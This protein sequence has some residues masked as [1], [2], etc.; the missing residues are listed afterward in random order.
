[1]GSVRRPPPGP[2]VVLCAILLGGCASLPTDDA[3]IETHAVVDT[4]GTHLGQAVVPLVDQHPGLTGV[5]L[6]ARGAD[7]F[8][9]RVVLAE[10]A[11]RTLDLQYFSWQRDVVGRLLADSVLRAADRGV[12]VRLLLDDVG[13]AARD[14]DLLLLDAHPGIEVRLF[15][16]LAN[17]E[18][19]TLSFI[20]DFA[21]ANRRM[22]NKSFTADN[23]VAILGGRNIG[24]EYFEAHAEHDFR[25]RGL[26]AIGPVVRQVSA[27]FDLYWNSDATFR[28]R[29]LSRERPSAED[30]ARA[31]ADLHAFVEVQRESVYAAAV[32]GSA[33]VAEL[34]S[35][36]LSLS[37]GQATVV[38]DDPA[39]INAE[40][41]DRA[42]HLAPKLR[43]ALDAVRE[44][45]IFVS[46]YFVPGENGVAVLRG[47]RERGIRVRVLTNSLASTDVP[48]VHSGYQRYRRSL[49]EAGVD[50]YEV[51]A[52]ARR[53]DAGAE[54]RERHAKATLHAKTMIFDRQVVFLGSMNLDPRSLLVNTEIG[55]LVEIPDVA[56][57]LAEEFDRAVAAGAYRLVL[58]PGNG[59]A[60]RLEWVSQDAGTETRHTSEPLATTWQRCKVWFLSLLPIEPLL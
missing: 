45:A 51:R 23:Q 22:H 3:R 36:S 29:A 57:L 40:S 30:V 47:M 38:Y 15:N 14:A 58:A 11:E 28:I 50:L 27:Q 10:A 43:P 55:A 4:D 16:P 60:S 21:R 19:R 33:I 5:H 1:M 59:A 41:T 32:R 52:T 56:R 24:E 18:A 39:K 54:P 26:V 49:L 44:E 9:A 53:A 7:A 25:D 12:R 20:A 2:V 48:A 42:T 31:R 17:R 34:R 13:T 8:A 37:W 46:P 6:I 35:R